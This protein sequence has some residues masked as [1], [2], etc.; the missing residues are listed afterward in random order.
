[1]DDSE[2]NS[3]S[4]SVLSISCCFTFIDFTYV[5]VNLVKTNVPSSVAIISFDK[6]ML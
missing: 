6:F 3:F 1:M 2:G 4:K 5:V